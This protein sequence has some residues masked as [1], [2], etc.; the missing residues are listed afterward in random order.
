MQAETRP[1]V[2][3]ALAGE[4]VECTVRYVTTVTQRLDTRDRLTTLLL[5]DAS[6]ARLLGLES[7]P[8]TPQVA[9]PPLGGESFPGLPGEQLE[10]N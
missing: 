5:S 6:H 9:F 2:R 4:G 1:S 10:R 7:A 3:F 8:G